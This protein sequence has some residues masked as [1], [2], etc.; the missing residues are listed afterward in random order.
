MQL[1]SAVVATI[2]MTASLWMLKTASP[3]TPTLELL[4]VEALVALA[5]FVGSLILIDRPALAALTRV[6][7]SPLAVFGRR[8]RHAVQAVRSDHSPK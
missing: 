7:A 8:A 3:S 5:A 4:L 2:A 1:R 6:F